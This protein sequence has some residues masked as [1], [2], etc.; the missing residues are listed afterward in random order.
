MSIQSNKTVSK[1]VFFNKNSNIVNSV[2][3]DVVVGLWNESQLNT[4]ENVMAQY[5]TYIPVEAGPGGVDAVNAALFDPI[6]SEYNSLV[7]E[8]PQPMVGREMQNENGEMVK[9][10]SYN[11]D[12]YDVIEY[13]GNNDP[14]GEPSVGYTYDSERNAFIPPCPVEGYIL[15]ETS[16]QWEPDPEVDYDLHGDGK[17]YRY[18]VETSSWYPTW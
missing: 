11:T 17:T 18:N 1:V 13:D 4:D 14:S 9:V 10:Q 16:L 12:Y 2:L 5:S 8:T 6:A 7:S 3:L 15:N